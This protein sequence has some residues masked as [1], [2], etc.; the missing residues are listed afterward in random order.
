[1]LESNEV[2]SAMFAKG[3]KIETNLKLWY[4]RIGHINLQKLQ[5]AIKRSRH[6]TPELY[7]KREHWYICGVPIPQTT[8]T[9]VLTERNVRSHGCSPLCCLGTGTNKHIRQMPILG[10]IDRRFLHAHLDLPYA[11]EEYSETSKNSKMK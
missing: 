9:S 4:K 7:G 11:A 5:H 6:W 3:I 1:M 10:H 8:P 2:K